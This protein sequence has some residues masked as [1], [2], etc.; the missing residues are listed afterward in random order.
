MSKD[1][2]N[3]L[4]F[5][6][7]NPLDRLFSYFFVAMNATNMA[8]IIV[9][10]PN[11]TFLA[12]NSSVVTSV[13]SKIN[14]C[15]WPCLCKNVDV[16][17]K[18]SRCIYNQDTAVVEDV[19]NVWKMLVGDPG[20]LKMRASRVVGRRFICGWRVRLVW[21]CKLSRSSLWQEVRLEEGVTAAQRIWTSLQE[22]ERAISDHKL[23]LPKI[24]GLS[25]VVPMHLSR[26]GG[27]HYVSCTERT[28]MCVNN[29][30]NIIGHQPTKCKTLGD[31]GV[32][33]QR[34][35]CRDVLLNR[36]RISTRVTSYAEIQQNVCVALSVAYKERQRRHRSTSTR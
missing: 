29:V 28:Y 23:T 13:T 19:Q 18:M 9:P 4:S 35:S 27:L 12:H 31:I 24:S 3:T 2:F 25:H 21:I 10:L 5:K 7:T 32:G 8:L 20:L 6:F 33:S 14:A 26:L 1:D 36:F 22:L 11:C 17:R 34:L 15:R 30:V 16:A